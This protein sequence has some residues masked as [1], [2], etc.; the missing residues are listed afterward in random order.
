MKKRG[1][2]GQF[3]IVSISFSTVILLVMGA[4][5]AC[6]DEEQTRNVSAAPE[7]MSYEKIGVARSPMRP[8]HDPMEYFTTGAFFRDH[9]TDAGSADVASA[10]YIGESSVKPLPKGEPGGRVIGRGKDIQGVFRLVRIH[11]DLSDWWADQSS[12]VALT[13]WLNTQTKIKTDMSVEGGA[14]RL[15]DPKLSKAPLV[16]FT[17]HDPYHVKSRSLMRGGA[18]FRTTLSE[19]EREALRKYLIEDG[20]FIFFDECAVITRFKAITKLFLAQ[21]RQTMPEYSVDRIPNDHEIYHNYYN[22]EGGPPAGFDVSWWGTYPP[23]RNF[24]T[25]ITIADHLGV[26]VC[27]RDYMCSM[28]SVD[29]PRSRIVPYN[30]GVFRFCTNVVVYAL[31]HGGISDYSQYMPE[32]RPTDEISTDDPVLVPPLK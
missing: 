6:T 32:D 14:V 12:L 29:L 19:P 15:T 22:M 8:K 16:F 24:L 20:G 7:D 2:T 3:F 27:E 28:D 30:P 10:V 18:P 5:I 21:L 9:V 31:T 13:N 17:G 11:H 26:L 25:G 1:N 23:R 4:Y